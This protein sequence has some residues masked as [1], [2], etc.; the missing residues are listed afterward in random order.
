MPVVHQRGVLV[1]HSPAILIKHEQPCRTQGV[2]AENK[3][4]IYSRSK[5]W[6]NV[7]PGKPAGCQARE[8]FQAASYNP[9][10]ESRSLST[11]SH[12]WLRDSSTAR[13][14]RESWAKREIREK[15]SVTRQNIIISRNLHYKKQQQKTSHKQNIPFAMAKR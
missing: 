9:T 12:R 3:K 8:T 15:N 2:V 10:G 1:W 4:W 13:K 5:S 7:E 11:G 14:I 6:K